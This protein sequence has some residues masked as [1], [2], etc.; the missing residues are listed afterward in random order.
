MECICLYSIYSNSNANIYN[1][2]ITLYSLYIIIKL[3]ITKTA[4]FKFLPFKKFFWLYGVPG[5][6]ATRDSMLSL[7][8][9]QLPFTPTNLQRGLQFWDWSQC[10]CWHK[11]TARLRI[12]MIVLL[13][14]CMQQFFDWSQ[15]NFWHKN[16]AK[17][18]V[19]MVIMALHC[20]Q[21]QQ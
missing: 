12:P 17:K 1:Y 3:I 4:I 2:C 21:W 5:Y 11:N 19:Q 8:T 14:C 9:V 13:V 18:I 20:N 7:V 15:Y 10:N 16:T 6:T